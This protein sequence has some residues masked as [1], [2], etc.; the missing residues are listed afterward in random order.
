MLAVGLAALL[1]WGCRPKPKPVELVEDGSKDFH[2]V[3]LGETA[4]MLADPD[5]RLAPMLR[6]INAA[7]CDFVVVLGGVCDP[8]WIN[9]DQTTQAMEQAR[10]EFGSL[11][12]PRFFVPGVDA[13]IRDTSR[14]AWEKRF[15]PMW[16][17]WTYK[18]NRFVA[19]CSQ[20]ST[21]GQRFS[22][23]Q[24][25]FLARQV[26]QRGQRER[27]YVFIAEPLWE[28]VS[29]DGLNEWER[30]IHPELAKAHGATVIAGRWSQFTDLPVRD[31]VR[32]ITAGGGGL[33]FGRLRDRPFLGPVLD[34][35][36]IHGAGGHH[37]ID[38][39]RVNNIVLD[40]KDDDWAD[41]GLAIGKLVPA[42][43]APV[44]PGDCQCRAQL[45]W[46]DRGIV[47]IAEVLDDV[48]LV[49]RTAADARVP[50][51][52]RDAVR[53]VAESDSRYG[54][55]HALTA[56]PSMLA[57]RIALRQAVRREGEKDW[58]IVAG[59]ARGDCHLARN[60]Y[61]MELLLPWQTLGITGG[62]GQT[63]GLQIVLFDAD[64]RSA[65]GL[66]AWQPFPTTGNHAEQ[67]NRVRLVDA[68]GGIQQLFVEGALLDHGRVMVELIGSADMADRSVVVLSGL[69]SVAR[70]RML[71]K[72]GQTQC[73]LIF[74][75]PVGETADEPLEV[76]LG[77]ERIQS[78]RPQ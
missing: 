24:V 26:E 19:L 51:T 66:F 15:G 77:D 3:V 72:R 64:D 36:A 6:R 78:I 62:A 65:P 46:D 22:E 75:R 10:R 68:E 25:R 38:L 40:G 53:L 34:F 49:E 27:L 14:R 73:R 8:A 63:L 23:K 11:R 70:G 61:L 58:R 56:A 45:G 60:G 48:M 39:P 31:G 54:E 43:G 41:R 7:M 17:S 42:R 2:V 57:G 32:Y 67:L 5:Q 12:M 30:K 35:Q 33:E 4:G 20:S 29:N 71:L 74:C 59:A 28:E 1:V 69:N 37:R 47:M 13:V 21:P 55:R 52:R 16:R 50:L 18:N 76:Y 9:T 44:N